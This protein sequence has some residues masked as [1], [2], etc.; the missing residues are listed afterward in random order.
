M[1]TLPEN[2]HERPNSDGFVPPADAVPRIIAA[3]CRLGET[4]FCGAR[5]GDTIMMTQMD[6]AGMDMIG[7]DQGFIDQWGRFWDRKE[8]MVIA[9]TAG[10]R[11]NYERQ[12]GHRDELFSEGLY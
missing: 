3:A 1:I 8:A 11:I 9:Y 5:H 6:A 10:Q 7:A 2:W 12:G 4:V